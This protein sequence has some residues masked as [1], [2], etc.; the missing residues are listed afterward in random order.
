MQR[1]LFLVESTGER[2]SALLNPE[3]LEIVRRS[4]IDALGHFSGSLTGAALSDDMLLATGGGVTEIVL[5]LL[6]DI[7]LAEISAPVAA[8]PAAFDPTQ[9]TPEAG[10]ALNVPP[11]PMVDVRELTRPLWN[12]SESV[13]GSSRSKLPILRFIWGRSWNLPA[14]ITDIAERFERFDQEGR[15]RRSFLRL[16]LRRVAE[17]D[18]EPVPDFMSGE[19]RGSVT[20]F[21]EF[22]GGPSGIDG[23]AVERIE[24]PLDENGMPSVSLDQLAARILGD[25][26][27]WRAIASF[28]DIDDP[29]HLEQGML[30]AVP[31]GTAGSGP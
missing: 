28:N 13:S 8:P 23:D 2:I 20:P 5:D 6:F 11:L 9:P 19:A 27:Q 7:D 25:A 16:R 10:V 26:A 29:L 18:A 21:F 3:R 4:G 22:P 1:A 14:V 12:L 31:E 15:P 24:L 30:I 17:P